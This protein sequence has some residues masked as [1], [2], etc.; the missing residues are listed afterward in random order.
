MSS[1]AS[2]TELRSLLETAPYLMRQLADGIGVPV[3]ALTA[4]N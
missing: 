3:G 4:N 1:R 2:L